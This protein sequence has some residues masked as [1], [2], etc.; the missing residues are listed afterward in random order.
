MKAKLKAHES[1]YFRDGWLEKALFEIYGKNNDNAYQNTQLFKTN[2]GISKLGVGKNMVKSIKYWMEATGLTMIIRKPQYGVK[3]T[4]IGTLIEQSDP[5]FEDEFTLWLLHINLISSF[6]K[7][8]TWNLFFNQFKGETFTGMDVEK[9]ISEYLKTKDI[10]FNEKSLVSDVHVLLNMYSKKI[11]ISNP[12]ENSRCPL[13]VLGLISEKKNFYMRKVPEYTM[14]PPLIV[15]YAIVKKMGEK[16]NISIRALEMEEMGLAAIFNFERM[17][18]NA[19]LE[20]LSVMHYL[21][22][23]HTAGLDNVH[24]IE[25]ITP[26][27][28]IKEYYEKRGEI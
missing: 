22:V 11:S 17:D 18:I 15:L 4:E 24:L 10:K 3:L 27:G 13:A 6:E 14:I 2:E 9:F 25:D 1:F 7:A 5:Y 28:I 16:K 23:E 26:L 20:K 12:E 19:Y 8:T 21:S